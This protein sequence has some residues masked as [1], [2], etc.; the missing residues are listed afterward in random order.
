MDGQNGT[1]STV[2][3]TLVAMAVVA[4]MLWVSP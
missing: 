1:E 3:W 4:F 2:G